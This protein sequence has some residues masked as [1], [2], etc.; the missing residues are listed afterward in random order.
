MFLWLSKFWNKCHNNVKR[1]ED[2]HILQNSAILIHLSL[3]VDRVIFCSLWLF[4]A[5]QLSRPLGQKTPP[6]RQ[7]QTQLCSIKG[8]WDWF[9][10]SHRIWT[11]LSEVAA[12]CLHPSCL[13]LTSHLLF[14]WSA[15]V[16]LSRLH[17]H[18]SYSDHLN[19]NMLKSYYR[20]FLSSS[21]C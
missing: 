15:A 13:Y 12:L 18:I 19:N 8:S 10:T 2:V 7:S 9:L 17:L 4:M 5:G 21:F 14:T 16:A 20:F 1:Y 3:T 6:P 11:M